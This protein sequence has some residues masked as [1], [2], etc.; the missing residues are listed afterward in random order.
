MSPRIKAL[1]T[2]IL[3]VS[4]FFFTGYFIG[5]ADEAQKYEQNS[6]KNVHPPQPIVVPSP[7]EANAPSDSEK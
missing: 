6:P 4:S 7:G 1:V 3:L 2:T 5:R